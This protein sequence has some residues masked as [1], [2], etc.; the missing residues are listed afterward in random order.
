MVM[1]MGMTVE[2]TGFAEAPGGVEKRACSRI[3]PL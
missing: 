1:G 2:G 3:P